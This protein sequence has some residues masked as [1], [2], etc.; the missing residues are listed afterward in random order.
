MDGPPGILLFNIFIQ[1][2]ERIVY[3]AVEDKFRGA[4]L[5]LF[6]C[7][8]IYEGNR[9][10]LYLA[11]ER[12]IQVAE[13]GADKF[14]VPCPPEIISQGTKTIMK[15]AAR[16]FHISPFIELIWKFTKTM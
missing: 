15:I 12:G 13:S 8:L 7:N 5:K 9:V 1:P 11:P 14:R 10:V 2:P 16:I 4:V 6:R 3:P